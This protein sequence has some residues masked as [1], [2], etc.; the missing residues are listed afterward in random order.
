M[1][2]VKKKMNADINLLLEIKSMQIAHEFF[3]KN[4]YIDLF[5][6]FGVY[7]EVQILSILFR[8]NH[9]GRDIDATIQ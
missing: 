8:L 7:V 6:E 9:E 1:K 3:H 2:R 5:H 4:I